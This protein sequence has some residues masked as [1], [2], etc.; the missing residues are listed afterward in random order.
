MSGIDTELGRSLDDARI[1]L[2]GAAAASARRNKPRWM[3]VVAVV[4]L[5]VCGGWMMLKM[6]GVSSADKRL[7]DQESQLAVVREISANLA[8]VRKSAS[9]PARQRA[10]EP[11]SNILQRI[12]RA[13]ERNGLDVPIAR[14]S[15]DESA[16]TIT[17]QYIYAI[18]DDS[19]EALLGWIKEATETVP[20]L[21]V[22]RISLNPQGDRAWQLDV[23]FVRYERAS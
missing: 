20:G 5:L 2:A 15:A 14:E 1:A 18:S 10:G 16:G 22:S 3:L 21:E 6:G 19:L 12:D 23:T 8:A 7:R 9:D 13:G 17:R 11:L 4:G